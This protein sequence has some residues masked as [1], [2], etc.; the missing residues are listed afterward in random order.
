MLS[1]TPPSILGNFVEKRTKSSSL[2]SILMQH[3]VVLLN[4]K[5][6]LTGALDED[7][8][9]SGNVFSAVAWD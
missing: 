4:I 5:E 6:R 9:V 1:I 2:I 7:N 3:P 8:N